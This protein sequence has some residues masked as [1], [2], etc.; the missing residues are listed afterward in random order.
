[1]VYYEPVKVIIDAL[2]LVEVILDV[3]IRH[4]GLPHSIVS[5]WGLVFTSKFWL[6]LCYF[7]GIKRRLSIVFHPQTDGQTKRQKSAMEIYLPAYVNF[8]Q[9]DWAK[10]LLMA[11]FAY[12]NAKNASTSH[13]PFELNYGFHLRA[14]YKENVDPRS[15]SKSADELATKLRELMA[16]CRKNLP[17]I[18]DLQKQ[19]Y[20]K[21]VKPRS[22]AP[23]EK[24]WLNSKYIKI[25]QNRKIEAKFFRPY[26]VL[27]QVGK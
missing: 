18:Q 15:Q 19:Y 25:K 9:N 5:D 2:G 20:N 3:V 14:S 11:E 22:Y 26:R 6:S 13:T 21:H 17:H 27:H 4:H 8:E 16:V 1:M 7:L 12:N 10:L 24:I 23:G